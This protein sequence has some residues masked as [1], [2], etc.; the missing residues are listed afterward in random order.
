MKLK[1]SRF[2]C[3]NDC[4]YLLFFVVNICLIYLFFNSNF[5]VN[6]LSDEN[7]YLVRGVNLSVSNIF[8]D[9]SLYFIWYKFLNLLI[10]DNIPVYFWNT[11]FT[12][13][14]PGIVFYILLRSIHVSKFISFLFSSFLLNFNGNL[15]L[16]IYIT[17]Y[18]SLF[19][20]LIFYYI[21]YL[22]KKFNILL[23]SFFIFI[24][25]S[26]IRPEYTF[27]GFVFP[28]ILILYSIK[29]NPKEN[30]IFTLVLIY[31]LIMLIYIQIYPSSNSRMIIAFSQHIGLNLQEAGMTSFT[32]WGEEDKIFKQFFG[33]ATGVLSAYVS[34]P[35]IFHWHIF[36]NIEN[37]YNSF[38]IVIKFT[39]AQY[40]NI[41]FILIGLIYY[42]IFNFKSIIKYKSRKSFKDIYIN[43][44]GL[45]VLILAFPIY[46]FIYPRTHYFF[47]H[48]VVLLFLLV[49]NNKQ[50]FIRE[51]DFKSSFIFI[52][53][54]VAYLIFNFKIYLDNVS[55]ELLRGKGENCTNI[56]RI[57]DLKGFFVNHH[58]VMTG[59]TGDY[60]TYLNDRFSYIDHTLQN[61]DFI[62][63]INDYSINL[64]IIN[65]NLIEYK[66]R[67]MDKSFYNLIKHPQE[68]DFYPLR[69]LYCKDYYLLKE[70]K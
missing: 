57:S 19:I 30:H 11:I 15:A 7:T 2:V 63:F 43:L 5:D 14:A 59:V 65:H 51:L 3:I 16:S 13:I 70:N 34:N 6:I 17:K 22:K 10:R 66:E 28:F 38:L 64:I 26:F 27:A 53:V 48:I 42:F 23:F 39:L 56:N 58:I 18:L 50:F 61:G 35:K 46:F 54:Y 21:I 60:S 62:K 41:L 49:Y 25:L 20:I 1:S 8:N 24:I 44:F 37:F 52:F 69:S 12:S 33:D 36:K 55:I 29:R 9:G 47:P 68:F 45:F 31:M 67:I 40:Q 4:M 32:P